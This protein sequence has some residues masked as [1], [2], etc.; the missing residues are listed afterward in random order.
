MKRAAVGMGPLCL[1]DGDEA[2]EGQ[3]ERVCGGKGRNTDETVEGLENMELTSDEMEVQ[4]KILRIICR[5][6]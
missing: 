3:G 2:G 1:R 5:M 6:Y 4:C